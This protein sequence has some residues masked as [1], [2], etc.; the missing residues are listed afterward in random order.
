MV[1]LVVLTDWR[2]WLHRG[3]AGMVV[4]VVF[5][6]A[7]AP[8]LVTPF[9][10]NDDFLKHLARCYVISLHGGDALLNRFYAI[11]W[12][13]LPNLAI[14]LIV[15]WLADVVG[16]FAAGKLIWLT[17]L[18]LL[19]SGPHAIQYALYRRLS[20]GPLV[21]VLFIYNRIDRLGV[22]N[23]ELGI[24][25]AMWAS[26]LWIML[27]DTSPLRRSA[28]SALCVI[29]LFFTHLEAVAI[30]GLTI[31]SLEAERLW[32][33]RESPRRLSADLVTLLLPFLPAALFLMAG[34]TAEGAP[35]MPLAWG[36]WRPRV[37]GILFAVLSFYWQADIVVVAGTAIGFGWLLW[38]GVLR[39]PRHAW[40][41]ALLGG[42]FLLVT[43]DSVM[44]GWGAAVRLPVALLFV[45]IGFV[46]WEF[47]S[48]RYRL[49]FLTG[50]LL[51]VAV[52]SASVGLAYQRY[53]AVLRDFQ[54][55]LPLIVPGSRV[56]VVRDMNGAAVEMSSVESLS[57]LVIIERSSMDSLAFSHPLQQVLV[58]REPYRAS[59]GGYDDGPIPLP[60]LVSQGMPERSRFPFNPSG[61]VYWRDWPHTY[62]YVYVL[63]PTDRRN[64]RPDRLNLLRDGNEF[65]LYQVRDKE[66][67]PR[68]PSLQQDGQVHAPPAY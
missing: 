6:L 61:R 1:D 10:A 36:G 30:Y 22:V 29:L 58:V 49:I 27:R 44:G 13:V 45:L 19:L 48:A 5:G 51:L 34:P 24:G 40:V 3:I 9:P 55:S 41:F 32:S 20:V 42:G 50:L 12:K 65:Q 59:A 47:N 8:L 43:P 31:A 33:E 60:A 28:I 53:D 46:R 64:P 25:L 14:D 18:L 26:A 56:L 4:A 23:Y 35:Y 7:L 68:T 15:P 17:Y 37:G 57:S 39:V 63:Q 2:P 66:E 54:A 21:A 11:Q 52:R 67:E 38:V 16:I 62:D